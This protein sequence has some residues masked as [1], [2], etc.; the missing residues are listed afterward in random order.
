MFGAGGMVT[1]VLNKDVE[2]NTGGFERAAAKYV[3]RGGGAPLAFIDEV[4]AA[5]VADRGLAVA[6]KDKK[7][8]ALVCA[9]WMSRAL[10]FIGRFG[11]ALIS[12]PGAAPP[13]VAKAVYDAVLRPYH[14]FLVAS[15]VSLAFS[16]APSRAD[17]FKRMSTDEASARDELDA[18]VR[19][20][21]PTVERL[22]TWF[23]ESGY[24]FPDKA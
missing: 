20:V 13:D 18:F 10:L 7:G 17:F 4:L 24:N 1:G 2:E 21:L 19:V 5:E 15:V 9:L 8:S 3:S 6:R 23:V 12:T 11:A 16:L 22:H 14:G